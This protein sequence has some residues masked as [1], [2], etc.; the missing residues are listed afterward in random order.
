[1][2]KYLLIVVVFREIHGV[3]YLPGGRVPI[4]PIVA[5]FRALVTMVFSSTLGRRVTNI[6]SIFILAC[7]GCAAVV[8]DV[9]I[10]SEE[11]LV[12][13]TSVASLVV[14]MKMLVI[15]I[16]LYFVQKNAHIVSLLV[17]SAVYQLKLLDLQTSCN[18]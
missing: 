18:P 14:L 12:T 5:L 16:T 13:L 10:G 6:I 3:G 4:R 15:S 17:V 9:L 2:T 1:M 11:A 8:V 7:G